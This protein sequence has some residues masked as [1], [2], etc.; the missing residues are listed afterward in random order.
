VMSVDPKFERIKICVQER[1]HG[2]K[3]GKA[4]ITFHVAC[5]HLDQRAWIDLMDKDK[6]EIVGSLCVSISVRGDGSDM[7]PKCNIFLGDF[8]SVLFPSYRYHAD[9]I[10]CQECSKLLSNQLDNVKMVRERHKHFFYCNQHH[11]SYGLSD[12]ESYVPIQY[13]VGPATI[14]K[15]EDSSMS[16]K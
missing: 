15:R 16:S 12:R 10:R 5:Q 6:I 2:T 8:D 7:C 3:V 14:K 1:D 4:D 13:V 11:D 9:C